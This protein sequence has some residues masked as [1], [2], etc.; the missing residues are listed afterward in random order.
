MVIQKRGAPAGSAA[1]EAG[2]N[3]GPARDVGG[4]DYGELID[5]LL[6]ASRVWV[7][8]A[9]RSVAGVEEDVTLAQYRTLVV[10]AA[11]GPRTSGALAAML[12][13]NSSTATRMCDRL[14]RKGLVRRRTSRQD[15]REVRLALTEAGRALVDEVTRRRREELAPIVAAVPP[16]ERQA[17]IRALGL[18]NAAAGEVPD[19]D[20]AAGWL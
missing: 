15:R 18:L 2:A 7:A 4:E 9:A 20:W 16:D 13:V 12:G 1:A 6:T 17:L 3:A 14:V 19:Q 5:A 11:R 8:V 10:L